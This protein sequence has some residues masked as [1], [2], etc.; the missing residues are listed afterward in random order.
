MRSVFHLLE[1]FVTQDENEASILIN[2]ACSNSHQKPKF[3]MPD[4][5]AH[6]AIIK[7]ESELKDVCILF[8]KNFLGTLKRIPD[9]ESIEKSDPA[10]NDDIS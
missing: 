6:G 1:H 9:I 10:V 5:C 4:F 8:L 7:H 2:S 3:S